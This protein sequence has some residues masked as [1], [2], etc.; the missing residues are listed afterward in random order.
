MN[1]WWNVLYIITPSVIK[2]LLWTLIATMHTTWAIPTRVAYY[3]LTSISIH[4][5]T[6]STVTVTTGTHHYHDHQQYG[7]TITNVLP[8]P[9]L[10][11]ISTTP[12]TTFQVFLS[13]PQLPPS[14]FQPPL[15][16]PPYFWTV[17]C[18]V[19]K[20]SPTPSVNVCWV[21]RVRNM[22]EWDCKGELWEVKHTYLMGLWIV[23]EMKAIPSPV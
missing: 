11:L 12:T 18:L 15:S 8:P 7:T 16:A 19:S 10:L 9:S 17:Y 2:L 23:D 3:S 5:V 6:H 1:G 22:D 21:T 14:V 4:V 13:Q 20:G